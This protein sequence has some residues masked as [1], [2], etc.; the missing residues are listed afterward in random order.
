MDN[1]FQELY[2][3][4]DRIEGLLVIVKDN[5][6][7]ESED[8]EERLLNVREAARYLG[9][10]VAT[11]YGRT[12]KNEIPFYKRGKKVYFKKSELLAWIEEGRV[13]SQSQI[14]DETALRTNK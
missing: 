5:K 11:L 12:S 1:P 6:A 4:L 7:S 14:M 13:K 8:E 2:E 10:A 9:D 3:R